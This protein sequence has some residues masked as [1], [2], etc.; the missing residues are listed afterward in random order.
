M[1]EMKL[2]SLNTPKLNEYKLDALKKIKQDDN[3]KE[4]ILKYNLTDKEIIASASK[5]LKVQ[6]DLKSCSKCNGKCHKNPSKIQLG[7]IFNEDNRTF[8]ISFNTCSYYKHMFELQRMFYRIDFPLEFLEFDFAKELTSNDYALSRK[9]ALVHLVSI[10]KNETSKGLYLVG[11]NQIGKT[12]I[13][14]LFASKYIDKFNTKVAFCSS[15]DLFKDLND[16]FNI[17]DDKKEA[18]TNELEKLSNI[19]LLILDGF[20]NEYKSEYMCDNYLFPLLKNRINNNKL[21]LFT[22]NYSLN[23]IEAMYSFS[24]TYVFKAKQLCK[25]INYLAKEIEIISRPYLK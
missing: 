9:K 16:L 2:P 25:M 24:R 18:F 4:I 21:T 17:K 10:L 5:F 22:S 14:A 23:E 11:D 1:E 7:L 19:D 3:L 13:M 15:L 8:D 20:G 12:F 6:E